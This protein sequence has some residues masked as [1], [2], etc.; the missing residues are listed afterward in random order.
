[1]RMLCSYSTGHVR[2]LPLP[3]ISRNGYTP[4]AQT[5]PSSRRRQRKIEHAARHDP[6]KPRMGLRYF[7]AWGLHMS[8]A[9]L[10]TAETI[11]L[12]LELATNDAFRQR[13]AEKPAAAL[14]ELGVPYETVVNL[15]AACLASTGLAEKDAFKQAHQ[16]LLSANFAST[17]S[18]LIPN[19]RLD[20][21]KSNT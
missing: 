4:P 20:Y 8:D 2:I 10:T 16:Q 21:G 11:K 15:N 17:H 13:Y 3:L 6:K 5:G 1:M 7:F 9:T 12:L 19:L 18:M 14:V